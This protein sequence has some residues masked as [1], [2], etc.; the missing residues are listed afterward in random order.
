MKKQAKELVEKFK[1]YSEHDWLTAG[2][3]DYKSVEDVILSQA[4]Q[5]ALICVEREWN[6]KHEVLSG[7][8]VYLSE[9]VLTQEITMIDKEF[10]EVKQEINNL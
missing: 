2:Y 5:C 4:K 3:K 9:D 1:K 10:E 8:G 6:A 7:I